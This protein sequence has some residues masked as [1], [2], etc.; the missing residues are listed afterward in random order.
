[1]RATV[2]R[3]HTLGVSFGNP[4]SVEPS[5]DVFNEEAYKSIDFAIL[6]ARIY[7][8]KL[9][10]PLVDNVNGN[11]HPP[12]ELTLLTLRV[13]AV[14]QLVSWWE[15]PIHRMAR[16]VSCSFLTSHTDLAHGNPIM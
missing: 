10:I 7:G 13:I 8:I 4:L 5:L 1:M 15:I 9:L 16:Y 14:V 2:V 11:V 12:M 6:V 3:G